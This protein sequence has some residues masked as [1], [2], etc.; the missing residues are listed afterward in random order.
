MNREEY[1]RKYFKDIKLPD[2]SSKD[3]GKSIKNGETITMIPNCEKVTLFNYMV[4][5]KG[6]LIRISEVK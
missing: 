4:D 2:K 6:N 5:S 1:I 3:F